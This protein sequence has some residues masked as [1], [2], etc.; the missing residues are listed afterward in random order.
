LYDLVSEA[1][2]TPLSPADATLVNRI[3]QHAQRIHDSLH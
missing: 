2:Q 1:H 3:A